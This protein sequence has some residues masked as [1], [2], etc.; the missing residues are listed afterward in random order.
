MISNE[1]REKLKNLVDAVKKIDAEND[2]LWLEN[3]NQRLEILTKNLDNTID[4]INTCSE[5]ELDYISE[6]FEELSEHFQSQK[7]IDCVKNNI[8]R[9]NNP[10]LQAELKMEL[11]YMKI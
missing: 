4:Y 6:C 10:K 11:E 7:L 5:D 1:D 9:F 3:Y 8:A 2:I